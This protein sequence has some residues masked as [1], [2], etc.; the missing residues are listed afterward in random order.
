MV[1]VFEVESKNN[2]EVLEIYNLYKKLPKDIK[3]MLEKEAFKT[4]KIIEGK[5]VLTKFDLEHLVISTGKLN[6]PHDKHKK[7]FEE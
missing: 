7:K 5:F 3:E 4:G 6:K 1:E 2:E